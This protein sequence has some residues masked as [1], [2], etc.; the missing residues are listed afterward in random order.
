[1]RERALRDRFMQWCGG[2]LTF[3][4]AAGQAPARTEHVASYDDVHDLVKNLRDDG[5]RSGEKWRLRVG[6]TSIHFNGMLNGLYAWARTAGFLRGQRARTAEKPWT[7]L[8]NHVAHGSS[9]IDTPV[10]AAKMLRDLAEFIN[11]LWGNTTPGGR[12]YPAPIAR[13]VTALSWN[14]GTG[15]RTLWTTA[16]LRDQNYPDDERETFLL[17]RAVAQPGTFPEDRHL[18]EF[19]ARFE[20]TVYPADY[21][22]GPGTRT[23]AL[24]WLDEHQPAGDSVDPV[25]RVLLLREHDGN[26]YLPMRP[27]AAAGIPAE[28]RTGRWHTVRADFP[29]DAYAH[30][31][32]GA[33]DPAHRGRPGRDCPAEGCP[34]Q[35]LASGDHHDAMEA[36]TAVI[37][38]IEPTL[39]PPVGMPPMVSCPNRF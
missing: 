13:S 32:S 1:M 37:G 22:W 26:L 35:V 25:D 31:R 34:V 33:D 19:D 2:S 12:L 24:L 6:A 29:N 5:R 9:G 11:Q 4:D 15:T 18:L 23:E 7:D 8:R 28:D 36:A 27:A 21:L 16:A 17:V 14:G 38:P 3:E 30:V 10:A 20:T 39:P